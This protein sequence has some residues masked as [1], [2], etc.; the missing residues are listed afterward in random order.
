MTPVTTVLGP[1]PIEALGITMTHEHLVNDVASW[2]HP[3]SSRGWE[4]SDFADRPVTEDLLWDL[5]YDPFGNR[6][7]CRL[8]DVEL[9][10]QEVSRYSALGGAS[11][12]ETTGIGLGRDLAALRYI[13]ERTGIH[14]IAGTGYYLH[15]AIPAEVRELSPAAIAERI[16]SDLADGEEGARPGI[17]GEIG[18]GEHFTHAEE[19]SLRGACLARTQVPLPMQIH[20]PAWRRRADEVLDIVEEYGIDPATVVLCHMGPSGADLD[21]QESVLRRGAYVQYDMI[22]MELFYA[23]QDAQCP[24]DEENATWLARLA[25]RGHLSR[26]L[27]SQDIFLK[28]LLRRHGGPGYGHILQYFVPRLMRHGFDKSAIDRL[29]ISNPRDLFANV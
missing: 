21:Y 11:I 17:I 28:S 26:L 4:P 15:D 20:L 2:W 27:I 5:K 22:G 3:T 24:S 10:V 23:D 8:D 9:V 13:S 14:V 1:V 12:I 19:A 16:L 25:D 29:L 6:D 7:N 18:V